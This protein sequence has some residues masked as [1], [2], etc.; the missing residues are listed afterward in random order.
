MDQNGQIEKFKL[1]RKRGSLFEEDDEEFEKLIKRS[2]QGNPIIKQ[3]IPSKPP[4]KRQSKQKK[5]AKPLQKEHDETVEGEVNV[6]EQEKKTNSRVINSKPNDASDIKLEGKPRG[7]PKG[8]QSAK[9]KPQPTKKNEVIKSA[10]KPKVKV[11]AKSKIQSEDSISLL[12]ILNVNNSLNDEADEIQDNEDEEFSFSLTPSKPTRRSKPVKKSADGPLVHKNKLVKPTKKSI[13]PKVSKPTRRTKTISNREVTTDKPID[14]PQSVNDDEYLDDQMDIIPNFEPY[15]IPN[16]HVETTHVPLN[17]SRP[18]PTNGR[19]SIT[20][21]DKK[22]RRLSLSFRG[23]RLSNIKGNDILPHDDIPLN[24]YHNHLDPNLPT[25]HKLKTL[26]TWICKKLLAGKKKC[27]DEEKVKRLLQ[28]VLDGTLDVNWWG[29]ETDGVELDDETKD[30]IS[31]LKDKNDELTTELE[32]I[33]RLQENHQSVFEEF[34]IPKV[35][36]IIP[37]CDTNQQTLI[38]V[39]DERTKKLTKLMERSRVMKDLSQRVIERR[40]EVWAFELKNE[41]KIDAIELLRML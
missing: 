30:R 36:A 10:P 17:D 40:D 18:K 8:K 23:K 33:A 29:G 32:L 16:D 38:K 27:K 6:I 25:P 22:P 9:A 2:K 12:D 7:R 5:I 11:P 15:N 19:K 26:L 13:D 35:G 37:V 3:K 21:K 41:C 34:H 39:I 28:S 1:T 4:R 24:E 20:H 14:P 31:Y